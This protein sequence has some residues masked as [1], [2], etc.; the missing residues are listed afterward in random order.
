MVRWTRK[1]R[2]LA[3]VVRLCGCDYILNWQHPDQEMLYNFAMDLLDFDEYS[4][5]TRVRV[6][7]AQAILNKMYS[8]LG[9]PQS[10]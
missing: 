4:F 8:R 6:E 7:E 1:E 9:D 3:W 10:S 2:L 5:M